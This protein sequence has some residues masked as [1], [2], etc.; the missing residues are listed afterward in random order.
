MTDLENILQSASI[1]DLKKVGDLITALRNQKESEIISCSRFKK[2]YSDYIQSN[3]SK[4][5]FQSIM[6][7][8][9]K[10]VKFFGDT[11]SI[12]E[13]KLREIESFIFSI[14]QNSPKGYIV[15]YRNLKGAFNKALDW[16]YI[17]DNPVRRIKLP[18]KQ[19]NSPLFL[20][21]DQ[22]MEVIN[23]TNRENTKEMFLFLFYTGARVG[24]MVS[25]KL[26]NIDLINSVI[27]IGDDEFNTKSRKQRQ[28]PMCNELKKILTIRLPNI[29]H[30]NQHLFHKSNGFPY[31]TDYLSKLFK[32][33]CRLAGFD[34]K[35][36]LHSLRHSAASYLVQKG[37]PLAMIKEILGHASISTTE[38][39]SHVTL[40]SLKEA[41]KVFD[42]A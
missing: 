39:Y 26:K 37:V 25:L 7:T 5:Y 4:K 34:E 20:T 19:K 2:D 38:I 9:N 35:F 27:T 1:D 42:A 10:F 31:T 40:D 29:Y 41:V 28:I 3:F 15:D 8:L 21:R 11:S 14:Q 18:R 32:R 13:I 23:Y 12:R 36:H 22:V 30:P 24:E 33:C 17:S 6:L 16:G